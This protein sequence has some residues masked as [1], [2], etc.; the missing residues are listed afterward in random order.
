MIE[1]RELRIGN[2]VQGK[3]DEYKLR[4]EVFNIVKTYARCYVETSDLDEVNPPYDMLEGIPLD[5]E[6]LKRLGFLKLGSDYEM[7]YEGSDDEI[8][9]FSLFLNAMGTYTTSNDAETL[10]TIKHVHTLQN[11]FFSITGIELKLE[12]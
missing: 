12:E 1:A 8:H 9:T 10:N 11:L 6:W 3:Y 7:M 4:L 5:E 2:Y